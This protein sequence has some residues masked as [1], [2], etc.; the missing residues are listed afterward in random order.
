MLTAVQTRPA[1]PHPAEMLCLPPHR[2]EKP[3]GQLHGPFA[4]QLLCLQV[5]PWCHRNLYRIL[6]YEPG[7]CQSGCA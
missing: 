2:R 1:D 4:C 3:A 7:S 6:C 5:K